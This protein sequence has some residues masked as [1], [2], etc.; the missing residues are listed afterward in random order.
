MH[1][2][3]DNR[4]VISQELRL[5]LVLYTFILVLYFK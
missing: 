5:T 4:K 2:A 1:A 3:D